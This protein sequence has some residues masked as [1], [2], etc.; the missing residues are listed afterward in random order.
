MNQF[1]FALIMLKNLAFLAAWR[2]NFPRHDT[3]LDRSILQKSARGMINKAI[4]EC[5]RTEKPMEPQRNPHIQYIN[6]SLPVVVVP[7]YAGQRYEIMAPDTIDLQE[8]AQ[9]AIH[10][11]TE[12]TDP[13]ADY[14]IY[15]RA[16]FTSNPAMMWHSESDIVQAKFMEALPLLRLASGSEQNR[17]VEQRWME[18]LRQMQGADGLLYLPK[19]G[20]PWCKFGGYGVEPP[21]DHYFAIWFE[22]RLLGAITLYYQLTGDATWKEAGQKLV[23]SVN[24]LAIQDEVYAHFAN[25]EFGTEGRY[26]PPQKPSDAVSN[27]A[28]W[29]G[30]LIQGLANYYR[31]THYPPAIALAAKLYHWVRDHSNHFNQ[32]GQFLPEYPDVSHIH[33][34]SHTTVLLAVLDYGLAAGD[35]DAIDFARRGFEHALTQGD[36]QLGFFAEWLNVPRPQTLEICE[37]ADMI[38]VAVKLSLSGCAD[39]WDLVDRWTRNLFYEAQLRQVERIYWLQDR[40]A[41][42]EIA[43]IQLPAHH[44]M[45]RVAER[46]RGAFG[47]WLAPNDYL[48][49]YPH[50][51]Q[52]LTI[53]IMH[54]CTGNG[55]RA[56]YYIWEN[57]VT[58]DQ[59]QLRLNLLMN[60]AS[61]WADIHSHIPYRGQ[62]DAIVKQPVALSIRLP[63]WVAPQQASCLVNGA[64]RPL[65]YEGRYALVGAVQPGDKVSLQFPLTESKALLYIEKRAYRILLRGSTCVAIDP[66]GKN[67]P[68]FERQYLRSDQTRWRAFQRFVADQQIVW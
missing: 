18:I 52:Y 41:S 34:H 7:A 21:G 62:V 31:C 12:P 49:D 64:S 50:N 63:E 2:L 29:Y 44:S 57:Q 28:T 20:R 47:G 30:W 67:F 32:A 22:G 35:Q 27:P 36:C 9:L 24:R 66:P 54:C 40:V 16:N 38:G 53:G 43:P 65:A 19:V 68:L 45:D 58:Y 17:H 26:S 4:E 59:G 11:L 46:N 14:E 5:N 60:R 1:I 8:M 3:L 48:P 55:A 15:W 25:H 33:F 51:V 37:L 39:Y 10:G 6:P 13:E 61:P 42:S 23:D 56:I